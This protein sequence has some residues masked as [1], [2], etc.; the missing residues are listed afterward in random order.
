M[1]QDKATSGRG[2]LGISDLPRKVAGARWKGKKVTFGEEE[3]QEE[4]EQQGEGEAGKHGRQAA[5]GEADGQGG[6]EEGFGQVV[7]CSAGEADTGLTGAGSEVEGGQAGEEG[8]REGGRVVQ[9]RMCHKRKWSEVSQGKSKKRRVSKEGVGM[10]STNLQAGDRSSIPWKKTI[11]KELKK[12][13][14]RSSFA[15]SSMGLL[16]IPHS[17]F[18][19]LCLA[20]SQQAVGNFHSLRASG[21]NHLGTFPGHEQREVV[22]TVSKE[23][24]VA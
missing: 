14:S 12:V 1:R 3:E 5:E 22:C 7:A 2:G 11:K 20:G 13:N 15:F 24:N 18:A 6:G 21:S 10:A 17:G 19:E 4:G 23:G 16:F 9:Q 8:K